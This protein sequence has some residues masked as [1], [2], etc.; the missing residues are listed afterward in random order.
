MKCDVVRDLIPLYI[1]GCLSDESIT[2][3]EEHLE[4]CDECKGLLQIMKDSTPVQEVEEKVSVEPM[5]RVS[6]WKASVLQAILQFV[7]FLLIVFGVTM[8]AS[9]NDFENGFWAVGLIVPATGFMLSLI[10]WYFVRLYRDRGKFSLISSLCTLT[11]TIAGYVWAVDHYGISFHNSYVGYG[12]FGLVYG[13]PISVILCILSGVFA[14]KYGKLIGKERMKLKKTPDSKVFTVL[15][16]FFCVVNSLTPLSIIITAF[17]GYTF[18][19]RSYPLWTILLLLLSGLLAVLMYRFESRET[20]KADRILLTVSLFMSLLNWGVCIFTGTGNKNIAHNAILIGV[21]IAL[22][23][24]TVFV[25]IIYIKPHKKR[26]ARSTVKVICAGLL[27][28][29][30]VYLSFIVIVFSGFGQNTVVQTVNSPTGRYTAELVDSNQ[31]ALGGDTVVYVTDNMLSANF[32]LFTVHKQKEIVYI[33]EW[34][35]FKT[36]TLR[37]VDKDTLSVGGYQYD[38]K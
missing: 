15:T 25:S 24:V 11:V 9:D 28:S 19:I 10:N 1:D 5:E 26:I 21:L 18:D 6:V 7:S 20:S 37:W 33:G 32:G 35:E 36:M 8:E 34:G 22:F 27:A 17:V 2:I 31:G 30:L 3:V 23:A 14:D 29:L 38:M 4:H 13:I 12:F 16:S